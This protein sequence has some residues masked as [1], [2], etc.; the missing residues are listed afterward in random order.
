MSV[1][2][3]VGSSAPGSGPS[4]DA[5]RTRLAAAL[6]AGV[7]AAVVNGG[8][9]ELVAERFKPE[10]ERVTMLGRGT[11]IVTVATANRAAVRNGVAL[12]GLSGAVLGLVFGL[13]GGLSRGSVR[14]ALAAGT[15]GLVAGGAA[16][17]AAAFGVFPPFLRHLD[18]ISGDL[19]LPMLCHAA[20][21]SLPG[22]AAGLVFGLGAGIRPVRTAAGG[23]VG[24]SLAA[25]VFEVAGAAVFPNAKTDQPVAASFAARSLAQGHLALLTGLGIAV[26][27]A[28]AR[29]RGSGRPAAA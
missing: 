10:P 22:A 27:S 28:P 9:G 14:G 26:A 1:E 6:A 3:G 16:G 4:S 7:V 18:P 19:V 5:R 20:V 8:A 21:W 23:L 25:V 29:S 12:Y 17:A 15:S 24:A 13:A 2:P 11:G